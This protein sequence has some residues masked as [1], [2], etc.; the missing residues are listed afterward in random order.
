MLYY[1]IW[2][3]IYSFQSLKANNPIPNIKNILSVNI[4]TIQELSDDDI[5]FTVDVKYEDYVYNDIWENK[6][7]NIIIVF[8]ESLS[9]I[10]SAQ[11]WWNDN[12]PYLDKIQKDGTTFT[13][14][15]ANGSASIY[16][17][18]STFLWVPPIKWSDYPYIS[19][20]LPEY[21]NDLWYNT[22]YIST[23]SLNFLNE[24]TLLENY[25]FK[26]IIWE[27][28]FK[29]N[30]EYTFDAAPDGDLYTKALE[31]V[32]AQTWKYFMSIPSISFHR[33]Y[34]TPYGNSEQE[35]LKYAD[36]T[37]YS[38]YNS[39]KEFWFFESGVLIIVWDHRKREPAESGE[40]EAFWP[41][42]EYKSIAS[43]VWSWINA[44]QIN[45]NIIQHSDFYYS[46]KKL[47]WSGY[48]KM[49]KTYNNVFY[50]S[51]GRNWWIIKDWFIFPKWNIYELWWL[52]ALKQ[53]NKEAYWY[54][55]SLKKFQLR[56]NIISKDL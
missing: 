8:G 26:K 18:L 22:I 16:A 32:K 4:D 17:H 56:D 12:M 50:F 24:R 29:N 34:N 38:F 49:D 43:I 9:A 39:L 42:W 36:E 11:V 52:H 30:K 15:I 53:S 13:N 23:A 21:L 54:Y 14:F 19:E 31:E 6:D 2:I 5:F 33:P 35:A 10:D 44:W 45:N 20:P 51:T 47:L 7:L 3:I 28:A 40:Y 37:L 1:I 41:S 46:I 27:E 25:W 48:V 55:L